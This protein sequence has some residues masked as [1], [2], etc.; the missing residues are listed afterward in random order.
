MKAVKEAG[1]QGAEMNSHMDQEEVLRARD[2]TGLEIPS[3]CGSRHWE[4]PL[5]HPDAKVREEGLE[6]LRQTLRDA[7]RYGASSV[8]LVPAVVTKEVSYP[9]AYE[10]SQNEI[11]KALPLAE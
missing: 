11:R 8:L 4:K 7:K 3:V 6:A 2:A 10:R 1:F 9:E 5:S